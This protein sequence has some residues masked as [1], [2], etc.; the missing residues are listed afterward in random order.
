VRGYTTFTQSRGDE[1]AGRL[2]SKF[3]EIAREGV[4]AHG[5]E[6]IE[7]RGDEALA[8]FAS[9][10]EALWAAV[11]LQLVFADEVEI[12]RALPL[13]V[14]EEGIDNHAAFSP[15]GSHVV[16]VYADGHA[17]DW[18]IRPSSWERAAC[19]IAGRTLTKDEWAQYLPGRSY[20]PACTG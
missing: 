10:R 13:R 20:S 17:I 18:D 15:D 19:S 8:V 6:M 3:S 9:A 16:S 12:D 5:G 2:A 11:D 4:E 1:A 7:L 14:G